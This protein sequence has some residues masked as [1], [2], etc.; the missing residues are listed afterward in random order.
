VAGYE[1]RRL[2]DE[3]TAQTV[4]IHGELADPTTPTSDDVAAEKALPF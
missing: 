1:V 3:L 4:R 2:V